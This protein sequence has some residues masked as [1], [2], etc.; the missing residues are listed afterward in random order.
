MWHQPFRFSISACRHAPSWLALAVLLT[1]SNRA[2]AEGFFDLYFGVGFPQNSHINTDAD[3]PF[4]RADI[5]YSRDVDWETTESLGLRGGYWFEFEDVP[6]FVG[7]GL[8]FSFYRAFE[9]SNFARFRGWVTPL[10]P[11]LM[12]RIPLGYSEEYPGGRVQPYIAVGPGFTLA[13]ADANLS[14]IHP[15]VDTR[16]DD[17]EAAGFGV[18]FDGRAGLAVQL[19]RHF[20]LF[21]EY[22][23]TYVKPHFEDHIDVASGPFVFET[24]VDF[25]PEIETHHIVFGGSFRF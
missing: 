14:Q 21:T 7:I 24:H 10:T 4:V 23:F 9:D 17:L 16:F 5:A 2:G 1:A 15:S 19:S 18:G 6:S 22:R 11:L 3:D 12:F 8:D 25:D 13:A 20:A